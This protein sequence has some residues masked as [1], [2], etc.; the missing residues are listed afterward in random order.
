MSDRPHRGTIFLEEAPVIA[1]QAFAGDQHIL[2][3][4]APR[5]AKTAAPG[6]FAHLQCDAAVPL[7]RPL[8]IMGADRDAGTLE[9]LYKPVGDGLAKLAARRPGDAVS[10][11]A[12]IGRGF[13]PAPDRR[14]LLAIGG[15]VG[16]PPMLFLAERMRRRTDVEQLVLMG[17]EVPFPFELTRSRLEVA[18][19]SA[20]A[21]HAVQLLEE[22]GVASRLAS[23]AGLDGCFRGYVPL[24]MLRRD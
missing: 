6:M 23:N 24:T 4:R 1:Q 12:P 9:F 8:S 15:G 17:S 2:R 5:A 7:R 18:G 21:T 10:V 22:W 13:E 16:I 20:D 19:A 3:V 11:L 14:V